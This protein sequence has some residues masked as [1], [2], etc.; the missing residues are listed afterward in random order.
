MA[1]RTSKPNNNVSGC[2][3][4][5]STPNPVRNY[6]RIEVEDTEIGRQENKISTL[7]VELSARNGDMKVVNEIIMNIHAIFP[8]VVDALRNYGKKRMVS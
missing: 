6:F 2:E 4:K 3:V 8:K 5:K 1:K 7:Q